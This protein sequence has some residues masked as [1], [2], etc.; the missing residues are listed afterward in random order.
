[1]KK[2]D[3]DKAIELAL[4]GGDDY[5][6]CFT[7]PSGTPDAVLNELESICPI[8]CIGTITNQVSELSF[9]KENDEPYVIKTNAYRHFS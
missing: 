8:Y 2:L 1:L 4:S 6:L 5:E 9:L 7:L 3:K